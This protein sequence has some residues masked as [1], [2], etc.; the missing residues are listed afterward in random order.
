MFF[1]M[2][3]SAVDEI[4]QEKNELKDINRHMKNMAND[5]EKLHILINKNSATSEELQQGNSIMENEFVRSLKVLPI[6][7][8]SLGLQL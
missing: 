5:L 3:L 8:V 2:V 6:F 4:Q 7:K 1:L